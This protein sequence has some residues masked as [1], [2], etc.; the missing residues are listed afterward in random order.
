MQKIVWKCQ[1]N[2]F[3]FVVHFVNIDICNYQFI[4]INVNLTLPEKEILTIIIFN[5]NSTDLLFI[6]DILN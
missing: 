1:A 5:K 2:K 4:Q 6:Y 3:L